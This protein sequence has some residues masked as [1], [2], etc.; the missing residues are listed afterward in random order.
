M[1]NTIDEV[2]GDTI[3]DLGNTLTIV[4]PEA[5]NSPERPEGWKKIYKLIPKQKD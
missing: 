4:I 5:P 2:N 1:K 3:D